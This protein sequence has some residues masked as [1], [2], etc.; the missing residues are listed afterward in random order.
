V[1][2]LNDII[3]EEDE[4]IVKSRFLEKLFHG[5]FRV[6][7]WNFTDDISNSILILAVLLGLWFFGCPAL[8]LLFVEV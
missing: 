6:F 2:S 3:G 5:G 8:L 1:A 7:V 4:K